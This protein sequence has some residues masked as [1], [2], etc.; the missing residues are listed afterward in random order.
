MYSHRIPKQTQHFSSVHLPHRSALY[1]G[2]FMACLI[3]VQQA[4]FFAAVDTSAFNVFSNQPNKQLTSSA[5][6]HLNESES[7]IDDFNVSPIALTLYATPHTDTVTISIPKSELGITLDEQKLRSDANRYDPN[8]LIPFAGLFTDNSVLL[9]DYIT[10]DQTVL[11]D[12]AGALHAKHYIAPTNST[13]TYPVGSN[14]LVVSASSV[15]YSYG[16]AQIADALTD[17]ASLHLDQVGLSAAT[18]NPTVTESFLQTQASTLQNLRD[19]A[20]QFTDGDYFYTLTGNNDLL[21][22]V[23][24]TSSTGY[25]LNLDSLAAFLNTWLAPQYTQ[26]PTVSQAGKTVDTAA[27]AQQYAKSLRATT[28]QQ[29]LQI[30]YKT[31]YTVSDSTAIK[32]TAELQALV[33]ELGTKYDAGISIQQFDGDEIYASYHGGRSKIA[34]STY[35]LLVAYAVA[36]D[37]SNGTTAWSDPTYNRSTR[38]CLESMLVYST[39]HCAR[40]WVINE[41][42]YGYINDLAASLQLTG[43]CFDCGEYTLASTNDQIRLMQMFYDAT[44]LDREIADI[45]L[46]MLD[47]GR[48]QNGI[49]YGNDSYKIY[50]KIGWVPGHYN[51]TAIIELPNTTIALS[52]YTD[53]NNWA[54]IRDI[55]SQVIPYFE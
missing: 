14:E 16:A 31:L 35:K 17:A 52:I 39:N 46:D 7:I 25:T 8:S 26:L 37:V 47:R 53:S 21:A 18:I 51:D 19:S 38:A 12:Y 6:I 43:T 24:P 13:P 20:V 15:G 29:P 3:I 11:N 44:G 55:T 5:F 40:N 9:A 33:T 22:S 1:I 23:E 48:G 2:A 32:P 41:Y 49:P 28:T 10:I 54:Q 34:A 50:N 27:V 36:A 30:T 42:G 45:V 4:L